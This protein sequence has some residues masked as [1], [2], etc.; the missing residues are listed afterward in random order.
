MIHFGKDN[1]M[2]KCVHCGAPVDESDKYCPFCGSAITA[3]PEPFKKEGEF[4][5]N[6]FNSTGAAVSGTGHV[7]GGSSDAFSDVSDKVQ[8]V[9]GNFAGGSGTQN[10]EETA[11]IGMKIICFLFPVI[12]LIMYLTRRKSAP[13]YA[14]SIKMWVIAGFIKAVFLTAVD[15]SYTSLTTVGQ[16]SRLFGLIK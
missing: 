8:Q 11:P 13:A 16:V 1:K 10:S 15:G 12:G 9:F 6:S 4:F 2:S 3:D 14:E 7:S 5:Q